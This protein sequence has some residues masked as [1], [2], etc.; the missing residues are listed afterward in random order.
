M[1]RVWS[2]L[3]LIHIFQ[4]LAA[5]CSRGEA[6]SAGVAKCVGTIILYEAVCPAWVSFYKELDPRSCYL[7]PLGLP[8]Q[9]PCP[10]GLRFVPP[11]LTL[12]YE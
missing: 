8:G 10:A 3:R 5:V 6:G 7:F 11:L 12:P 9:E 2:G 4:R 1:G